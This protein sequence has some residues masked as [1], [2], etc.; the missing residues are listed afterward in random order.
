[1]LKYIRQLR[2]KKS[3]QTRKEKT[4]GSAINSRKPPGDRSEQKARDH[5]GKKKRKE[6]APTSW[7]DAPSVWVRKDKEKGE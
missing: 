7:G 6:N 3:T 4:K 5:H 1:M 2:V